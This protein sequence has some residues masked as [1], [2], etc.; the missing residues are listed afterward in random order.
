[1][2]CGLPPGNTNLH[3]PVTMVNILGD[4]WPQD[5]T[6]DWGTIYYQPNTKLHLYSKKHPRHGRKMGHFNCLADTAEQSETIALSLY[7]KLNR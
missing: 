6:P 3:L 2:V 4:L 5:S 7:E 1:M